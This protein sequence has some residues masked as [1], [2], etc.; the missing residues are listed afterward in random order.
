M[1][2]L[3]AVRRLKRSR[4]EQR[5]Q[6]ERPRRRPRAGCRA[7]PRHREGHGP[8]QHRELCAGRTA[9]APGEN[10]DTMALFQRRFLQS[11]FAA[12]AAL[13]APALSAPPLVISPDP[14][15][16]ATTS[17]NPNV[18]LIL[19]D[20][21]SMLSDY[22]PDYVVDDHNPT[23]TTAACADAADDNG[24]LDNTPDACVA[25]DPPFN[26]ADFN[27][28]YYNPKVFYRPGANPDGTDMKSMTA[29]NTA[30]WTK[31]NTDPYL[32]FAT[33]N[34]ATGFPDR[35]WCTAQADVAT[36]GNCRQNS[37]Y[38]FP[39]AA[40]GFGRTTGG[41][42]KTV[43][44]APYYYSMQTAQYCQPPA[45]T[46]CASGSSI[47]PSVHTQLAAE[48]CVDAELTNCAAG[49][50]VTA[51]HKFS[52]V[53]WCSDQTTLANCQRKKIGNF[54]YAKHVG[55]SEERRVGK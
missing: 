6:A 45:M 19:D 16:T 5:G 18:M 30:N 40:F 27:G 23:A 49:N 41:A 31:V 20:S 52:G 47:N 32:S 42:V 7:L 4:Q 24:N 15:Q 29:A 1:R 22:M 55:R 48:F 17:I 54:I 21:G 35:V 46:N 51:A 39:N 25:G 28:I 14:L 38:Q 34:L 3:E 9:I 13:A 50:N 44:G 53:R 2:E 10:M 43:S 12:A 11:A 37:A 8:P 36:S 26:S 33:T